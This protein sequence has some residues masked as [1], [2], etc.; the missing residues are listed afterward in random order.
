VSGEGQAHRMRR[1]V[2]QCMLPGMCL[3]RCGCSHYLART[4]H[5]SHI[6]LPATTL[7][8]CCDV[9]SAL[10]SMKTSPDSTILPT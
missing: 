10:L 8:G 5:F 6:P 1:R 2:A 9:L 4:P 3:H 7:T